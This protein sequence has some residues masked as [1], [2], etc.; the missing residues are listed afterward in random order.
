MAGVALQWQFLNK[1]R[2]AP[3][4]TEHLLQPAATITAALLPISSN[5]VFPLNPV[6]AV[7]VFLQVLEQME[8]Q[9]KAKDQKPAMQ[10]SPET[11]LQ[12]GAHGIR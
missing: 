3:A 7:K 9:L 2:K 4:M 6:E 12:A 5:A 11:L 8:Q 1:P 10:I